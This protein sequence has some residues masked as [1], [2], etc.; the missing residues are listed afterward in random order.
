MQSTEQIW[1][2]DWEIHSV[3]SLVTEAM[4]RKELCCLGWE[5]LQHDMAIF[6]NVSFSASG[7][8]KVINITLTF[9]TCLWVLLVSVFYCNKKQP[10]HQ[11]FALAYVDFDS[12]TCTP[13]W[14]DTVG[15]I[16]HYL[17]WHQFWLVTDTI[18]FTGISF[19][20]KGREI[21][22]LPQAQR[23]SL[24]HYVMTHK[25]PFWHLDL[26]EIGVKAREGNGDGPTWQHTHYQN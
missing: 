14:I 7:G 5:H 22:K 12:L 19:T 17:Y 1:W 10:W 13:Q 6:S 3:Q 26:C 21:A 25:H 2:A 15:I 23:L 11:S 4:R 20:L 24:C 9:M 8:I 16:W 18:S